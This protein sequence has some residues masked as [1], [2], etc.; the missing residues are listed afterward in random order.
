MFTIWVTM[1]VFFFGKEKMELNYQSLLIKKINQTYKQLRMEK[2]LPW[3]KEALIFLT[4]Y[5]QV[6]NLGEIQAFT[7]FLKLVKEDLI[8]KKQIYSWDLLKIFHQQWLDFDG[9][10]YLIHQLYQENERWTL[11]NLDQFETWLF[12]QFGDFLIY[13]TLNYQEFF[14]EAAKEPL[15]IYLQTLKNDFFE[16]NL[17]KDEKIEKISEF[18][19][20]IKKKLEKIRKNNHFL[21]K[22]SEKFFFDLLKIATRIK[23]SLCLYYSWLKNNQYF[24]QNT[25]KFS[26]IYA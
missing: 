23:L 11:N 3:T 7:V 21:I 15:V 5:D 17:K 14:L 6:T 20:K 22:N 9:A 16:K 19:L 25:A 2:D 1:K 8:A 26:L 4:N 24:D 12:D 13:L 18:Y 10:N